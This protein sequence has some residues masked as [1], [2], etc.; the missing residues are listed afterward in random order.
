MTICDVGT[1]SDGLQ[2]AFMCVLFLSSR[3]RHTRCALVTGVQTCALPICQLDRETGRL[4]ADPAERARRVVVRKG[5]ENYL[6]LL[7]L[8]EALQGGFQG[9]ALILAH[10]AAR[11]AAYSRDGDMVGGDMPGWLPSLFRSNGS[12]ALTDR[13]G[14]CVYAGCPHFRRCF[15]ERA[16]RASEHAD[17]VVANHALVMLPNGK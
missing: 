11:W 1:S 15:I 4:I 5:R 7:N 2:N 6:C 13:R 9:R 17:P 10:L 8:E 12:H 16:S 3:R 14:E